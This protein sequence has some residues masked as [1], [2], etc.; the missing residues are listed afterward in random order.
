MLK[1]RNAKLRQV[2][3]YLT[4][5]QRTRQYL[6]LKFTRG[7]IDFL[8]LI[9]GEAGQQSRQ[10]AISVA[11]QAIELARAQ[12]V[13]NLLDGR[14]QAT[15]T[16]QWAALPAG[17]DVVDAGAL[18]LALLTGAQLIEHAVD[19]AEGATVLVTLSGRGDKDVGHVASLLGARG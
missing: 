14:D 15:A 16:T 9:Y 3:V 11:D 18:P 2:I 6:G 1:F 10:A 5:G 17:L 12:P 13:A 8:Q 4:C 19:P 7:S